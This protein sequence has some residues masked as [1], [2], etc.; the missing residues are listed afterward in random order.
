MRQKANSHIKELDATTGTGVFI[1][2]IFV[3][4]INYKNL[5]A[6]NLK[7]PLIKTYAQN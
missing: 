2:G 4:T 7:V 1:D 3:D 6:M 5:S